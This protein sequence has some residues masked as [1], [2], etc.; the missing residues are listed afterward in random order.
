MLRTKLS[1]GG[2][3]ERGSYGDAEQILK[4]NP[5]LMHTVTSNGE[6]NIVAQDNAAMNF[7]ALACDGALGGEPHGGRTIHSI[8]PREA[9]ISMLV[10]HSAIKYLEAVAV[11]AY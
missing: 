5:R 2:V 4:P 1:V 8:R 7:G 11:P 9:A 10:L 3:R 6:M